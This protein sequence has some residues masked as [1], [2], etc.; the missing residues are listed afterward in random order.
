MQHPHDNPL[1]AGLRFAVEL[2]AWITGPW[3]VAQWSGWLVLPALLVL[4]GLPAVFSTRNDKYYVVI[5][6]PGPARVLIE[7]LLYAVAATA[8]WLVWPA[9]VAAIA[10]VIVIA[11]LGVGLPRLAWLLR[12]APDVREGL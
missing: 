11:A 1:S 8:P 5:A 10:D 12:G 7:L 3:A 4:V 2:I 6:T 9:A